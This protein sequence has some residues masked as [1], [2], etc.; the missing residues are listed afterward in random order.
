MNGAR[1]YFCSGMRTQS[2]L[3]FVLIAVLFVACSESRKHEA[4][5]SPDVNAQSTHADHDTTAVTITDS[6]ALPVVNRHHYH[7]VEIKLMKF[8]PQEL[9]V[10]KGDTVVWVNNG[11][12]AHDVTAQPEPK[13]T[14]SSMPTG[15]SWQMIVNESSEYYCSIHVVMKGKL[16]V[17]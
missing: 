11:I 7:T 13:W 16:V 1:S 6:G 15:T 3:A 8:N 17:K 14:S 5:N 9:T 12:T 4:I 10:S 2:I